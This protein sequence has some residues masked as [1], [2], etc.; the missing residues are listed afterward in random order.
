MQQGYSAHWLHCSIKAIA[1]W[2]KKH[3]G[4]E[5]LVISQGAK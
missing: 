4:E 1:F 2:Q 3:G 5:G